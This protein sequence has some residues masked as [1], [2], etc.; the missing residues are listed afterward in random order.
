MADP[1]LV[2]AQF[3]F[4][5][6]QVLLCLLQHAGSLKDFHHLHFLFAPGAGELTHLNVLEACLEV[7]CVSVLHD[8]AMAAQDVIAAQAGVF[9]QGVLAR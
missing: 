6:L 1:L 3:D 9:V 2:F 8:Q 4:L 7:L 5:G